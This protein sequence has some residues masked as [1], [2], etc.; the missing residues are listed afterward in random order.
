ARSLQQADSGNVNA[1]VASLVKTFNDFYVNQRAYFTS[2]SPDFYTSFNLTTRYY[3]NHEQDYISF[4]A[5]LR[6]SS[7]DRTRVL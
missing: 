5:G 4:I 7:E 6:T 2:D 1:G 3:M